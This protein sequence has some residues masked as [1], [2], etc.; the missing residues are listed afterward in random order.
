LRISGRSCYRK[1]RS[2][3]SRCQNLQG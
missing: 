2:V 3:Q 1:R